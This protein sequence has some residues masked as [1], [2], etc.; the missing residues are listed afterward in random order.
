MNREVLFFDNS[1]YT[2]VYSRLKTLMRDRDIKTFQE[3]ANRVGVSRGLISQYVRG[4]KEPTIDMKIKIAHVLN[5]DSRV[6]FPEKSIKLLN[7]SELEELLTALEFRIRF[8]RKNG[9]YS[10]VLILENLKNRILE[11]EDR[12]F[13][14]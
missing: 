2:S 7:R 13:L 10:K 1:L 11:F 8:F 14:V 6:I 9:N 3:L 12:R 4:Y 5:T